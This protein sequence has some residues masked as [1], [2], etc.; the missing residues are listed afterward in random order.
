MLAKK[1]TTLPLARSFHVSSFSFGT[2]TWLN[3]MAGWTFRP[4][5]Q[6]RS[7]CRWW[8]ASFRCSSCRF[9]RIIWSWSRRIS[10]RT[11]AQAAENFGKNTAWC[12]SS[13]ARLDYA[14]LEGLLVDMH[15]HVLTVGYLIMARN[16]F[17][18]SPIAWSS[19]GSLDSL[20]KQRQTVSL[21]FHDF[22]ISF[23]H[24]CVQFFILI[25][26]ICFYMHISKI[27]QVNHLALDSLINL[28][29]SPC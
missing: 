20:S 23:L 25:H 15:E 4:G 28:G 1:A 11:L 21:L 7:W 17:T 2:W 18:V 9:P 8:F 14:N 24:C 6:P 26:T 12:V 29:A 22:D 5:Q 13:K 10:R 16:L 3:H 27:I 19:N